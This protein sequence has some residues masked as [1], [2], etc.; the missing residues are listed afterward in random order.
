MAYR[1]KM[2]LGK[3]VELFHAGITIQVRRD[4]SPFGRLEINKCGIRWLSPKKKKRG[5][6]FSWAR[7]AEILQKNRRS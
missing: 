5:P 6:E 3:S 1:A 4:G 2:K 7:L